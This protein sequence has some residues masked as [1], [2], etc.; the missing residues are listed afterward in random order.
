MAVC[1]KCGAEVNEGA[2]FC[3]SC[4]APVAAPEETVVPVVAEEPAAQ[5]AEVPV[6]TPEQNGAANGAL[7]FSIVGLVLASSGVLGIIFSAIARG[8]VKKAVAQGAIG[9][10]IKAAKILSLIGLIASILMTV[11]WVI[12]CIVMV[13]I[14]GGIAYGVQ[15]GAFDDMAQELVGSMD[16]N[17]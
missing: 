1:E 7:A 14:A 6:N 12:F 5:E 16:I 10:K 13:A 4:G 11:F 3:E 2:K 15:S 8:K 9:G 17:F